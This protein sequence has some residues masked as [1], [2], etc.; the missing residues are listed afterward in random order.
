LQQH[1]VNANVDHDVTLET[2]LDHAIGAAVTHA[3]IAVVALFVTVDQRVAAEL[4]ALQGLGAAD[5]LELTAVGAAEPADTGGVTSFVPL[6]AAI[7]ADRLKA[8]VVSANPPG[9]DLAA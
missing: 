6:H 2:L 1:V 9:F 4:F 8:R 3:R 7:P 5:R